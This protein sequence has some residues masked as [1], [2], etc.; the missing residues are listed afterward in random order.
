[1]EKIKSQR[2]TQHESRSKLEQKTK[3]RIRS[4]EQS[5]LESSFRC[6]SKYRSEAE[7]YFIDKKNSKDISL[8]KQKINSFY[9]PDN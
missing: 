6:S 1:M 3:E 4:M 9:N 5:M 2:K 7:K 8:K